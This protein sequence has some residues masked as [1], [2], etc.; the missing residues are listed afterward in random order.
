MSDADREIGRIMSG[1]TADT[2]AT[3]IIIVWGVAYLLAAAAAP[4][5]IGNLPTAVSATVMVLVGALLLWSVYRGGRLL[6]GVLAF[7]QVG[8]MVGSWVGAIH[9]AVPY[10]P[11]VAAVSMA[12][13]DFIVAVALMFRTIQLDDIE[14][15]PVPQE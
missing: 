13:M 7:V 5:L 11:G 15:E 4:G 12:A 9:W 10:D 3:A 6:A 2:V 1:L 14:I 8:S